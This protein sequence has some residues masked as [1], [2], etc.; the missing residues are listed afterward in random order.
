MSCPD[1]ND[2]AR[3]LEGQL[4][5]E[6]E[7]QVRAHVAGC[8]ECRS[9]LA[10]LSPNEARTSFS[11]AG[12]LAPGTR[13]GRY[14]VLGL[15][16]EGGM[17][18]VHA[19][20][21]PELDRKVALKLLKPE[22]FQEDTLALARQRL[23]REARTMAKLSH[24]HIA[25]LHDV[26]EYEGQL[27]LV[28][29]F[30]E[31]GTLRRWLSEQ[32]R[33][34]RDILERFR[35][36]ADGLAAS[37]AL[38]IVH[39]D[40]KPDNVLLT[41]GGLVRITDFGLAQA[42]SSPNAASPS[43]V[44]PASLT[45]T[46]AL[47][48]TLAY[49]APEQLRGERGDARSD[50]FSFCVALYEALN[51]QRPFEGKTREVLLE[52]M[53]RKAVRPERPGVPAWLRAVVRRGLSADPSERFASMEELRAR[54][55]WDS[56]AR[57]RTA[58]LVVLGAA[59]TGLAV[60]ALLPRQ[61]SRAL[62]QGSERHFAGVWDAEAQASTRRAFLS[63]NAPDA[64]A[65]FTAVVV[66]LERW[67]S[68]WTNAHQE[69]CEATRVW[70]EQPEQVLGLRMACLDA[71]LDEV[72]RVVAALQGAD[73]RT[74]A[75]GFGLGGSLASLRR[76]SDVKTLLEAVAPPE[77]PAV[78]AEVTAVRAELA[79]ANAELFAGHT[80]EAL[81]VALAARERAVLTGYRPLEAEAH[82]LCATLQEDANAFDDARASLVQA[83]L[84]AEAG[85]HHAVLARVLYAQAWLSGHDLGRTEE[86]WAHL[87]RAQAVAEPLRDPEF[88]ALL[89]YVR[90]ELFEQEGRFSEAEPLLLEALN[91]VTAKGL[92]HAAARAELNGRL[93]L[94]ARHQ[95]RLL[96]AKRWQEEALRLHEA[97]HGPDHRDTGR[98]LV[99]LGGTLAHAGELARAEAVVQ[100]GLVSLRRSLGEEHLVVARTLSNLAL[101]YFEWGRGPEALRAAEQSLEVARKSVP[102][103]GAGA[104]LMGMT[105]NRTGVLGELGEREAELEQARRSLA[106]RERVY[107]ATHPEVALDLHEV[108]RLLRLLGRGRDARSFHARGVA[109][110]EALLARGEMEGEG[111][112]WFADALLF[113]GRVEEARGLAERALARLEQDWGPVAPERIKA[114]VLLGDIHLARRAPAEAV[115]PLRAALT[116][117]ASEGVTS[118]RVPLA[119]RRLAQALRLS[120]TPGEACQEARR[121]WLEWAPWRKAYPGEVVEARAEK[122]RCPRGVADFDAT[123]VPGMSLGRGADS[124]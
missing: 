4:S 80:P 58:A 6:R 34:L 110:Q 75:R 33:P 18:R 73:A 23:E 5:S 89:N 106:H 16:G 50:Q 111:L 114:L 60:F 38:G 71:R 65:S 54:L 61:E 104:L 113:L 42:T 103:E 121:A 25:S 117:L 14:V 24:P 124:P 100:R 1:E 26:G 48:G 123:P 19:A 119:R 86:A 92:P 99:N 59:L 46:G 105:S 67:K 85:R 17:G 63:T 8:A 77:D 88:D 30:L 90:A 64:E 102:P 15:L 32:P 35:Q 62:C 21:D 29:E 94:L 116:A 93:G 36:A 74:V 81:K 28:M 87:N 3:H 78:L 76:C 22:R 43:P 7:Q 27:F 115:A 118:A 95:G 31:G 53:A 37:H 11:G 40:F 120:G 55:S 98:A 39:R 47:L 20:Y 41:K 72:A 107:G 44:S 101:I 2:L 84:A 97:L 57:R 112:R 49:G 91:R 68:D 79:R 12:P 52:Q 82:L 10:A 13:V 96:E 45:V 109:L 83:S 9:V 66:A 56:G 51:G 108:G 70:G 122:D 69:A